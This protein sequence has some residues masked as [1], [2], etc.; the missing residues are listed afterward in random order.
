MVRRQRDRRAFL[1]ACDPFRDPLGALLRPPRVTPQGRPTV[2]EPPLRNFPSDRLGRISFPYSDPRGHSAKRPGER[3]TRGSVPGRASKNRFFG[4]PARFFHVTFLSVKLNCEGTTAAAAAAGA[5]GLSD[6]PFDWSAGPLSRW[7]LFG[8]PS[9]GQSNPSGLA[10]LSPFTAST[11][12]A[13]IY[14]CI[15]IFFFLLPRRTRSFIAGLYIL[16]DGFV[17]IAA[18]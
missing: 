16:P 4:V 3:E 7:S 14:F 1:D 18:F 12:L 6:N 17:F 15:L 2:S 8:H 13:R 11:S 10:D 5:A 9:L